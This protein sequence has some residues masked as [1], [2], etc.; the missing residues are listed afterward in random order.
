MNMRPDIHL[1][2]RMS[3]QIR[4]MLGD[5][6]DEAT[7]TDT[8]EG[9]TSIMEIADRIIA[10]MLHD[11]AMV[12]AGEAEIAELKRRNER[13][14]V[15]AK[16]WKPLLLT[17]LNAAD[18]KKLERPRATISRRAGSVSVQITDEASIPSQLC[19]VK[20]ITA[21]DKA[22]IRKQIEAGETVPGAVLVRGDE[23]VSVRVA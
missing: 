10:K 12:A 14:A 6:Y 2:E 21:P 5:D 11:E 22:A 1:I 19:T 9:C 15:R 7:F 17:V 13:Q 8:L 16:G 18:L 20:T 23:T 3:A 4:E